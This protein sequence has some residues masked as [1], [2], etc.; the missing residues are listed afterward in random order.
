MIDLTRKGRKRREYP[1]VS[2]SVVGAIATGLMGIRV[3]PRLPLAEVTEGKS[4]ET[5]VTTMPQL[6]GKI[7]WA[8]LRNLPVQGNAISVR[9]TG[10]Q[11][12]DLTNAGEKTLVWKAS[13]AGSFATLLVDGKSLKAQSES[14][15]PGSIWSWVE[16]T[17]PATSVVHIKVP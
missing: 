17:V 16:V 6:T 2:Y 10:N 15:G 14:K 11:S 4:L 13:F 5:V 3:E 7:A 8:E 1:E 9:H 12:T